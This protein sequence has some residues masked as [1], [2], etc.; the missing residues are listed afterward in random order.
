M[1]SDNINR[2][3]SESAAE[4]ARRSHDPLGSGGG[5]AADGASALGGSLST[6]IRRAD[7]NIRRV[8][9]SINDLRTG[10]RRLRV[11]GSQV[12][13]PWWRAPEVDD[14]V[15]NYKIDIFSL[16]VVCLEIITGAEGEDIRLSM[17]YQKA[18]SLHFGVDPARLSETFKQQAAQCPAQFWAAAIACCDEN[19]AKRYVY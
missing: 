4:H 2:R 10:I 3:R 12:G 6:N 16:G 8:G 1:H 11:K 14:A 9:P 18:H 7:T 5:A 19:P 15:Y 17:S 13:S